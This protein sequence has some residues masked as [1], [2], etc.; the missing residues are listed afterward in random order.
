MDEK[1]FILY[2]EALKVW[3][4]YRIDKINQFF[5]DI[6][7]SLIL[8]KPPIKYGDEYSHWI[9]IGDKWINDIY[10]D[11]KESKL[12]Y[13]N[14]TRISRSHY[15]TL[16]DVENNLYVKWDF[17]ELSM[18]PCITFDFVL[19]YKEILKWNYNTLSLNPNITWEI[20]KNNP[21]IP[22]FYPFLSQNKNITLDIILNNPNKP[23]NFT[24]FSR[25]S[26]LTPSL[27]LENPLLQWNYYEL[28]KNPNISLEV[29]KNHTK[30]LTIMSN[31]LNNPFNYEKEN[32]IR[33]QFQN[34]FRENIF[35]EM[36]A[37]SWHP[38]YIDKFEYL[39]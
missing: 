10:F 8:L 32:F 25:N 3:K 1:K 38:K 9:K 24:Y 28:S 12:I 11:I 6:I 7:F 30:N 19:K 27:V 26:N 35:E 16:D 37:L 14:L 39:D 22:W 15:L 34:Y 17:Y 36:M 2:D 23:W 13:I 33:K 18:N 21:Y 31:L 5:K 29:F 4:A 20:V